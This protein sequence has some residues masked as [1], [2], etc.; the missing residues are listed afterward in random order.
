MARTLDCPSYFALVFCT[1]TG[2][3]TR[4]DFST[5]GDVATQQINLLIIDHNALVCAELTNPWTSSEAS[6]WPSAR[7]VALGS[8]MLCFRSCLF[9]RFI[10]FSQ[11]GI[12]SNTLFIALI[13]SEGKLFLFRRSFLWGYLKGWFSDVT[14]FSEHDHFTGN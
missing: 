5:L 10:C 2:L 3:S 1:C 13:G 9:R 14:R 8:L 4:S 11:G 6:A 7:C 12:S